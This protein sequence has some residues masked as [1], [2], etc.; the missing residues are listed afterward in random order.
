[1]KSEYDYAV[2]VMINSGSS[3]K[4]SVGKK[5]KEK[6]TTRRGGPLS[7]KKSLTGLPERRRKNTAIKLAKS[8]QGEEIKPI[9]RSLAGQKA[10]RKLKKY[11]ENQPR[12]KGGPVN[13]RPQIIKGGAYKG[14]KHSYA[15]G[16]KVNKL[17]F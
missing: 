6:D 9:I 11:L 16:G 4:A 14:K 17:N 2:Q 1:M 15:A 10:R 8:E 13:K 3:K 5:Q 7:D 12:N